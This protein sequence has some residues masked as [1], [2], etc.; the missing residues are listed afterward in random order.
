MET[1]RGS[2]VLRKSADLVGFLFVTFFELV[3]TACSIHQYILTGIE[4]VRGI[5]N[6]Q[7]DY[8][9]FIAIFVL[10]GFVAVGSGT[11]QESGTVTHVFEHN[12]TVI[13]GMQIF[14]HA[15]KVCAWILP[16]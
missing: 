11:T 16:C 5:G 4:R 3:D 10:D 2:N 12:K 15:E 8:W 7:F 9:I 14:F 6:L 1:P 13:F